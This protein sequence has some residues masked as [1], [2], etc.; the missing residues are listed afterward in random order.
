MLNNLIFDSSPKKASYERGVLLRVDSR[1]VKI[2]REA[3]YKA[4][5]C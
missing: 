3:D 5:F 4:T 2:A 1:I